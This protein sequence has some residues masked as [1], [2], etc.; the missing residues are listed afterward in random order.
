MGCVS[1]TQKNT[2]ALD[3]DYDDG[4]LSRR[5]KTAAN[6]QVSIFPHRPVSQRFHIE[7][8]E[9]SSSK[10]H[11]DSSL[12]STKRRRTSF[13]NAKV[14]LV[15]T[16]EL[17]ADHGLVRSIPILE[18]SD[19]QLAAEIHFRQIKNVDQ[20]FEEV[21][22]NFDEIFNAISSQYL[23]L[24]D[25]DDRLLIA[26]ILKRGINICKDI[27]ENVVHRTYDFG[28]I[29][30]VGVSGQVFKIE[31]KESR[32]TYAC[33]VVKRDD[34]INDAQTMETE[35]E[36]MKRLHHPNV[37]ALYETFESP[38]IIWL[39]LEYVDGGDLNQLSKNYRS[40]FTERLTAVVMK[41]I[42]VGL[43]YI[44]SMGVI[45]RDLKLE[46][47]LIKVSDKDVKRS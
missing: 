8:N 24:E 36:V 42:L 7:R 32:R 4:K 34:D 41:N 6:N 1:S 21:S 31:A 16:T 23:S 44:H 22:N 30:G 3:D 12:K 27:D 9:N 40:K 38:S 10:T 2:T 33:K 43:Y 39:V 46:N 28:E 11:S 20:I 15:M 29:I 45:H 37:V 5:R 17:C 47:I 19:E 18:S 25:C 26:T 35:L 14:N 13:Q